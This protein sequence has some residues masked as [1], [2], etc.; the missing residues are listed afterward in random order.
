M[1]LGEYC[2]ATAAARCTI[3]ELLMR[4]NSNEAAL[5]A[6]RQAGFDLDLLD[7]NLALS[8]AD[9]WRQHDMALELALAL[10]AAR[11]NRDA[12]LQQTAP[13]PR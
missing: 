5:E 8:V 9:R 3:Y 7:S 12:R 6:A 1:R 11:I 10:E 4:T 13:T 2:F